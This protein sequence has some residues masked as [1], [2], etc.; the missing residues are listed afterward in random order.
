MSTAPKTLTILTGSSRGMGRAL[1][2]QLLQPGAVLLGISRHAE[3]ALEALAAQRGARITQWKRDL[4]DATPVTVALGKWLAQFPPGAFDRARLINNAGLIGPLGATETGAAEAVA[5]TLRVGLEAAVLLTGA[6]L[7]HT[8]T[9]RGERRVLNISSGLGRRAMA[10]S[11]VYCAAK[12]GMDHYTRAV[13][14]E[15]ATQANGARIVSLAPGVI[16]T[17]MQTELRAARVEDF[18]EQARFASLKAQQQLD[19]PFSA[20]GKVLRY[21]ERPD[22]GHNPVADVRD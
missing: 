21:L 16:D 19:T 7:L 9:W 11:A 3:P 14:L 13:A 2:E 22:F 1:A 20:A 18:P 6:F 10:G 4:A 12:A 8:A 17:D 5:R 15:Q